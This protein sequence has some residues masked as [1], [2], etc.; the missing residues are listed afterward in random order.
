[1]TFNDSYKLI[2]SINFALKGIIDNV[3]ESCDVADQVQ[4]LKQFKN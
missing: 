4:I 1:M 2:Y 3:Y